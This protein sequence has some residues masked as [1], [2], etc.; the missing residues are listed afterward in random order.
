VSF[1]VADQLLIRFSTFFRYWRKKWEFNETVH[2]LFIDFR[3]A[4]DSVR[5]EVLYIILMEFGVT[6]K[7]V[8]LSKMCLNETH[9][10]ACIG[11]CFSDNF[12]IENGL[13]QGDALLPML[14]DFAL[15]YSIRKVQENQL[16]L[17]L[18]RTH[19]LL[20]YADEVNLL[21]D[22]IHSIKRNTETLNEANKQVGLEIKA[23]MTKYMLLPHYQNAGQ[24]HDIKI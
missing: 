16:G 3:K 13:K 17:K 24:N 12:L 14:F 1:D 5:R 18:N 4:Y 21:G 19:Q 11:K 23:V 20:S 7:L 9:S 8:R 10:K 22:N 6:M 2:R 15:E